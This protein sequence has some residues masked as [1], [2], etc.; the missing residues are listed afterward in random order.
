MRFLDYIKGQRKGKE[1]NHIE[2]ESMRDPFL[3]DAIDGLDSVNDDHAARI[4]EIQ[5]TFKNRIRKEP[6]RIHHLHIVWRTAAAV[7]AI[8]FV[9]GGYLLIDSNKTKLYAQQ[10]KDATPIEIFVPESFYEQNEVLIEESNIAL[11]QNYKPNIDNFRVNEILNSTISKD[12]FETLKQEM[13]KNGQTPLDIYSPD[14][15]NSP[16]V[17]STTGKPEPVIGWDRYKAYLRTAK[18]RPTDDAC[19]DAHGKVAVDFNVDDSGKP[20]NMEVPYSL[21]GTSDKEAVR[22]VKEGPKWT[23]GTE[24]VRVIIEF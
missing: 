23:T 12:E 4:A 16:V 11:V 13:M 15:D 5:T 7:A 2:R 17:A 3:A 1:A 8:L 19:Y 14:E 9:F 24:K 21:C 22:L 18:K 6:S 20:Y 10:N